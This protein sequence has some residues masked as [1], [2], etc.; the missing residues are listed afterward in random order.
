MSTQLIVDLETLDQ[1]PN[2][3]VLSIGALSFDF[4]TDFISDGI[5][6]KLS[7]EDQVRNYGRSISKSTVEW[8][9]KQSTE[10]KEILKPSSSDLL[11]TDAMITLNK[12]VTEQP[13][14]RYKNTYIWS[15]GNN[16]DF[17]ILD[18]LYDNAKLRPAYNPWLV[19]DIRT[20][21][22]IMNLHAEAQ[23]KVYD[24]SDIHANNHNSLED[25][26]CD[27]KRML[28]LFNLFS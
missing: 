7:V 4:E 3:V 13:G 2:S 6:I 10:A 5:N 18:S 22:D 9:S 14:F 28:R 16:F 21:I 8:W 12:W 25:C 27:A 11:L 20:Y 23:G 1:C 19:R 26:R 15:R 24:E 17:P